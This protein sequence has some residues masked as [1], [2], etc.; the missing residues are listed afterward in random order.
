MGSWRNAAEVLLWKKHHS[1]R[2]HFG[3]KLHILVFGTGR[4]LDLPRIEML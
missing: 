2:I 4:E 3:F 1:F